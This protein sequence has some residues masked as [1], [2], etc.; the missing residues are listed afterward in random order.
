M[1]FID[2]GCIDDVLSEIDVL[3]EFDLIKSQ[4]D[5]VKPPYVFSH[6]DFN[7][8]NRIVAFEKNESGEL[9]KQIYLLDFDYSNFNHRGI[10]FGRYFS[11]YRHKEDMFGDEGF[12]TDQEME[13]FLAEY[14]NECARIRGDSYLAED[15]N[16]MKQLRAES[17]VFTLNAYLIDVYFGLFMYITT[18][19][20][21]KAEYFLVSEPN[22]LADRLIDHPF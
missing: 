11:N 12:P 21:P 5:R 7:R 3:K 13:L 14:R 18:P 16:S 9:V 17:K 10:D 15:I 8:G 19:E 1:T 22:R 20:G 4:I 2:F 6:S